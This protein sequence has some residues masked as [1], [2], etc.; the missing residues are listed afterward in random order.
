M[1]FKNPPVTEIGLAFIFSD[2]AGDWLDTAQQFH[3][4]NQGVYPDINIEQNIQIDSSGLPQSAQTGDIDIKATMSPSGVLL[5]NKRKTKYVCIR[6]N[7]FLV[8]ILSG[9]PEETDI[10]RYRPIRKFA[11][12]VYDELSQLWPIHGLKRIDLRYV[13]KINIPLENGSVALSQY[14]N[15]PLEPEN[16]SLLAVFKS[17]CQF[18]FVSPGEE[19]MSLYL[20]IEQDNETAAKLNVL[21][22]QLTWNCSAFPEEEVDEKKVFTLIDKTNEYVERIFKLSL[23]DKTRDLFN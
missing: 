10:P 9:T 13:D 18:W 21:P 11:K 8:S 22:V 12:E 4:K 14:F 6:K 1:E 17:D 5:N 15:L 7:H 3:E 2:A 19:R 16:D 23:T 20:R